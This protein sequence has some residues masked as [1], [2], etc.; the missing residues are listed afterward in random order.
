MLI[1]LLSL[2]LDF[3]RAEP[4][5]VGLDAKSLENLVAHVQRWVDDGDVVG[6]EVLIVKNR[7]TVLDAC[8]GLK[9]LE[10]GLP[11]VPGTICCIRSMSKPLTGTAIQML[12]DEGKLALGAPAPTYLP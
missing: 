9:D 3:P 1:L 11:V 8:V 10:R 12:A 7:K 2:V 5:S 4:A 6:A